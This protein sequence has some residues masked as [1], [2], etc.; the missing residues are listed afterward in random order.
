MYPP[1]IMLPNGVP[2]NTVLKIKQE[3]FFNCVKVKIYEKDYV[4]GGLGA[5]QAPRS[6]GVNAVIL[7]YLGFS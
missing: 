7:C 2:K 6:S 3:G 4:G 1:K 5:A